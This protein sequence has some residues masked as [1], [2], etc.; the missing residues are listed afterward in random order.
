MESESKKFFGFLL[1]YFIV[2]LIV[3]SIIL[4]LGFR[5]ERLIDNFILILIGSVALCIVYSI[6]WLVSMKLIKHKALKFFLNH[7]NFK[8]LEK[9]GLT[10]NEKINVF[11][12]SIENYEITIC[13][14]YGEEKL[15]NTEYVINIFF[16][17]QSFETIK[18]IKKNQL[19]PYTKI[20]EFL[21]QKYFSFKFQSPKY[22][23]VE[24]A[25]MNLIE[26]LKTNNLKPI[27][28]E[29]LE[30]KLNAL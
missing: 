9:L 22:E 6:L 8:Q 18:E 30:K 23:I 19:T 1:T 24:R 21:I 12:G 25:I 20:A 15:F 28:N 7:D 27:S 14:Y 2:G 29:E 26:I 3:F 11:S 4:F 13:C 16:E 17:P 5:Q 10:F